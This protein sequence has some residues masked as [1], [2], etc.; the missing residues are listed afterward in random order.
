MTLYFCLE[1]IALVTVL[2]YSV[3]QTSI[4]GNCGF[5]LNNQ[6]QLEKIELT[7]R[8]VIES[9]YPKHVQD[10]YVAVLK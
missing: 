10:L 7:R 6:T 5:R 1:C 4:L 9:S 8:W 3:I 2:R